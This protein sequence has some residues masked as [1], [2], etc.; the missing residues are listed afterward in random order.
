[1][2][3]ILFLLLITLLSG[4]G[5]AQ[6]QTA[7]LEGLKAFQAEDFQTARNNFNL[8]LEQYPNDPTLLYNAGLAEFKAGQAGSALGLWR[9]ARSLGNHSDDLLQALQFAENTLNLGSQESGPL[10][11]LYRRMATAP[12]GF[13]LGLSL[14]LFL[15]LG[16]QSITYGAKQKKPFLDWPLS[17]QLGLPFFVLTLFFTLH[18]SFKANQKKGTVTINNLLTHASPSDTSPSLFELHEGQW[19]FIETEQDNW[20]QIRTQAGVSGWASKTHIIPFGGFL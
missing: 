2:H 7:F 14:I 5:I 12:L 17:L 16:W 8:L 13:W 9:K 3:N 1:M 4:S 11:S 19:V 15:F 18:L 6:D 10:I 20:L